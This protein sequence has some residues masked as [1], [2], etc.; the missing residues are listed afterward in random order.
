MLE[1][2]V[3]NVWDVGSFLLVGADRDWIPL[4]GIRLSGNVEIELGVLFELLVSWGKER[5][6][7]LT[8]M[9]NS[10][11]KAKTSSA[12]AGELLTSPSSA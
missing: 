10:C 9:M 11:K 12:A 2:D 1:N 5:I 8:F 4:T 7:R 3:G 6:E